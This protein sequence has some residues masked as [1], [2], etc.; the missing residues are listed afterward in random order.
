MTIVGEKEVLSTGECDILRMIVGG[1]SDREIAFALD[2]SDDL[3][4][5]RLRDIF[6][7]IGVSDIDAAATIAIKRGL[8]KIEL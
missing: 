4:E 7:K 8:V 3:V 2:A 5:K 1:M 6:D